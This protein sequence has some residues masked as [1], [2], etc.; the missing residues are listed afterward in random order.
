MYKKYWNKNTVSDLLQSTELLKQDWINSL[1]SLKS[2]PLWET[3]YN[4]HTIIKIR[5]GVWIVSLSKFST[6]VAKMFIS[7]LVK[8][9]ISTGLVD[10]KNTCLIIE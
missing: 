5:S 10:I 2:H 7:N 3:L 4:K 1:L 8:E 9:I 6:V